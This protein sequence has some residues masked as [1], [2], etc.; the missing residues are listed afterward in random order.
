MNIVADGWERYVASN[1]G[2]IR[3]ARRAVIA[4]VNQKYRN[5]LQEASFLQQHYLKFKRWLEL[6][7]RLNQLE[8]DL[9]RN[10]YLQHS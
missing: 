9:D 7:R 10:L 5:A 6:R 4:E 3:K 1:G 2:K 8:Q